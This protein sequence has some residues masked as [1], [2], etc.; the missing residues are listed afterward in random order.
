MPRI[1]IEYA[2]FLSYQKKI[3]RTRKIYD[4]ALRALPISQ[5]DKI[6]NSYLKFVKLDRVPT[7]TGISIWKRFLNVLFPHFIFFLVNSKTFFQM[8]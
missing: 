6:W 2:E 7:A 4:R 5:H 8:I 3:T 1:W